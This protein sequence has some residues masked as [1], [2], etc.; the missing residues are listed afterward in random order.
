M[1]PRRKPGGV[2]AVVRPCPRTRR[3]PGSRRWGGRRRTV[4]T[5]FH[6]PRRPPV[7]RADLGRFL[8]A[9]RSTRTVP[10][11]LEG[12]PVEG[13]R[14]AAPPRPFAMPWGAGRPR[15]PRWGG[16]GRPPLRW[17]R[18]G[19][20]AHARGSSASFVTV[21]EDV[22]VSCRWSS[23]GRVVRPFAARSAVVFF[24]R[25]VLLERPRVVFE[26]ARPA[27][28]VRDAVGRGTTTPPVM[29]RDRVAAI[30]SRMANPAEEEEVHGRCQG[31]GGGRAAS[32]RRRRTPPT[33]CRRTSLPGK[34]R[35]SSGTIASV[36]MASGGM[37][38][39]GIAS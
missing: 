17:C 21:G 38:L 6:R 20:G 24:R 39:G 28:A 27:A 16:I 32:M 13:A 10:G 11:C 35:R 34:R 15:L 33:T 5:V 29:G 3:T 19:R 2:G 18:R 25:T 31:G 23:I 22:V 36:E 9:D 26:G 7:R 30:A 12:D 4:S 37:A 14:P 1:A 8:P